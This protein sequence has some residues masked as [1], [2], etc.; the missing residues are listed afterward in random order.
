MTR[1]GANWNTQTEYPIRIPLA[2]GVF[3]GVPPPYVAPHPCVIAC[4]EARCRRGLIGDRVADILHD[5][6]VQLGRALGKRWHGQRRRQSAHASRPRANIDSC[7]S[8]IAVA[9]D[10]RSTCSGSGLAFANQDDRTTGPTR[11][12]PTLHRGRRPPGRC[13]L[14]GNQ[15]A[16]RSVVGDL[17]LPAV[18]LR[19]PLHEHAPGL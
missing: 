5:D 18:A 1:P 6:A 9:I 15:A 4:R 13:R 12:V 2:S 19:R 14:G 11:H 16:T 7:A 10:A 17:W 3:C 8:R